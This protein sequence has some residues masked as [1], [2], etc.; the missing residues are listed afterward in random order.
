MKSELKRWKEKYTSSVAQ[1]AEDP[2]IALNVP[3][4]FPAP[5]TDD[6]A[7]KFIESRLCADESHELSCAVV[8]DGSAVGAI[9]ITVGS[10]IRSHS[11]D[12]VFW[13]DEDNRGSGIM[14]QALVKKCKDAFDV[15]PIVKISAEVLSDNIAA[16]HTLNNAGFTLEATLKR[17]VTRDDKY[18]DTC[19]YA[20]FRDE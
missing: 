1:F 18:Y 10:G 11:A 6:D 20:K 19:L 3:G 9:I 5:F 14:S 12:I 16:R 15:F 7:K 17:S 2:E 13:L 8:C 4:M